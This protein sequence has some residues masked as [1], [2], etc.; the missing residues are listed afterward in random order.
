MFSSVLHFLSFV[1]AH[2][3]QHVVGTR[4]IRYGIGHSL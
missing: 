1:R 3:R 4:L 2:L